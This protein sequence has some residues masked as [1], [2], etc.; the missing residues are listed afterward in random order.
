MSGCR[1]RSH[2]RSLAFRTLGVL[3]F[4]S[5][6]VPLAEARP[7]SDARDQGRNGVFGSVAISM[8]S[9]PPA[10]RWA[11][12]LPL[13]VGEDFE[14]CASDSACGIE[15]SVHRAIASIYDA[16]LFTK[17][18]VVNRSVNRTLR[19]QEDMENFGEVDH[20]AA[21]QEVM[22]RG[23]GDCE[24]YAILKMAALSAS[25]VS[26]DDMSVVVLRDTRRN[27]HHAVL[28]VLTPKGYFILDSLNDKVLSDQL[29][30]RYEPLY[31][32]GTHGLWVHGFRQPTVRRPSSEAATN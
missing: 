5:L 28:A 21:P 4:L 20:W 18:E 27:V 15:G 22:K 6:A 9:V 26:M 1:L 24:D 25:G 3:A 7:S 29:V 17:L 23:R 11:S 32:V 31:S 14:A 16:P 8:K 10:K 30:H 19:Y 2:A 12:L 13:I